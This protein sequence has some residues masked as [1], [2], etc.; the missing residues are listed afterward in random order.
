MTTNYT[1]QQFHT[2]QITHTTESARIN[3]K[4]SFWTFTA[5]MCLFGSTALPSH[6]VTK[7]FSMAIAGVLSR[8]SLRLDAHQEKT[9]EP[10]AEI[11]HNVSSKAYQDWTSFAM[12][13]PRGQLKPIESSALLSLPPMQLNDIKKALSKP[14]IMLLGETGSGKSTLVKYLISHSSAPS[15][16]LDSHAAPDDWQNMNVIGIGRDYKAIGTEVEQL[17]KLMNSRYQLRGQGQKDFEPLIVVLDE[18]PACVAN[19]GK[20]FTENIMLLVRESRKISIKLII[21]AQGSEV[22]TLGIEGQGA[23]RECFAM[24]TLGK[25]ALN[26]AKSL[27]DEQ[28]LE[29]VSKAQYPA[30]LDDLP[31]QLPSIDKVDLKLLPLPIDYSSVQSA[32]VSNLTGAITYP[33]LQK[34]VDYLDGRDWTRDNSIKQSIADFKNRNEPLE[35]IQGYLQLLEV[36]GHIETRNAGRNGLEAKKI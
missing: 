30:M 1:S 8:V 6:P 26:S 31:C 18:F 22:K 34:I 14:H 27:K 36:Q 20:S 5:A 35:T 2:S 4:A 32:P 10:H 19:L 15:L 33:H 24:V 3:R 29:F 11:A 28:I 13:P 17:V 12:Q 25:F 7:I 23:I 9:L 16:V 21:L